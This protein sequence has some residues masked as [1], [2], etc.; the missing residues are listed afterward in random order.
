MHRVSSIFRRYP[1]Q[2]WLMLMGLVIST[3]GT[4][5]VWPFLTIYASEKLLL[6]LA[7]V[8]SLMTF[9]SVSGFVS[10]VIAGSLV[11]RFGRKGMMVIGLFG[12]AIVYLGYM[13]AK[14]F[15][16]FALLM[17]LSGS[18]NPLYRVG[19][20]AIVA[21]MIEPENRT[22]A[23]SL[24]RMGRNVG[25]ALGPI[26]G[27]LVLSRS[28]NIGFI[29]ASIALTLFGLLTIFF[30]KETLQRDPNR[31]HDS[32]R[33]QLRVISEALRNKAFSRM[34]GSF[35]LMEICATLMWVVLA[36]YIKQNY[37]IGE[38]QYSWIPTTN[39]LMVIFLQVLITRLTQKH[40]PTRVMPVGAAFYAVAMLLVALSG[41]FW[42]FLL[43][44]II[45]TFGELITAPTATA[46]VANLAPADQRGRYLGF[47]GLAWYVALSIGPMG[48]GF[49]SDNISIHAPWFAG[50]IVGVI[51]VLSFLS[52][53]RLETQSA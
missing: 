40:S 32:L 1:F 47:F 48:A 38:A 43:A 4:T 39:A 16:Q 18:F 45:M 36:V 50:A 3:T 11:D 10:S 9:N 20:D 44:M 15:W 23:Y 8:T 52:L 12:M 29:T 46:Y 26:L 31:H 21:D 22:Q 7:A 14:E 19:T 41:N 33:D 35:T 25:V 37:G 13:P 27:G 53:R 30:L 5:M 28:Y 17:L 42:G 34:V 6:P 24:V 49:L 2:F 51:S